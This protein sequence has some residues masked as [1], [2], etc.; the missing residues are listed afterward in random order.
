MGSY[1]SKEAP[2]TG[3]KRTAEERDVPQKREATGYQRRE[4]K[5]NKREPRGHSSG[6]FKTKKQMKKEKWMKDKE[7]RKKKR[8]KMDTMKEEEKA[9]VQP[10]AGESLVTGVQPVGEINDLTSLVTRKQTVTKEVSTT[11]GYTTTVI[12]NTSVS[13][14]EV[15]SVDTDMTTKTGD[16]VRISTSGRIPKKK[17][18][19]MLGYNGAGFQGLQINPKAHTIE[20][21]VF[22]ALCRAGAISLANQDDPKKSNWM[23]SARTDKGVSAAGN[24]ISLKMQLPDNIVDRL[25]K[26]LP[27]QIRVWGYVV[28]VKSFHAK[29][30]CDSRIYEYLLPTCAFMDPI[31]RELKDERTLETDLTISNNDYENPIIKYVA[32][33][34]P[35]EREMRHKYRAPEDRL[36]KFRMAIEQ[37]VGSHNFH[38][39]TINKG[40]NDKSCNRYIKSIT[41]SDP[42]YIHD[43]EW[44]SIK[45]H[46]QSFMLHQIRKM[47][48][49]G[50]LLAR[51]STPISLIPETF[52][53]RRINIPKAPALGLLLERPI[54]NTYNEKVLV[55]SKEVIR[56]KLTFDPYAA[57]IE[58]FKQEQIYAKIF[59]T[60][61]TE[62]VFDGYLT[63]LDAHWGTDFDYLNEEGVIPDRC[64]ITTKYNPQEEEDEEED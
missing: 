47:I 48:S 7:E 62:H 11:N 34:T 44:I 39:Y 22:D 18:A 10:T 25:N 55:K 40:A 64:L 58:K 32:A 51:T 63:S 9:P 57:E 50:L 24:V 3:V 26:I 13:S 41:V 12:T 27:P 23:R 20:G 61:N 42:M 31:K 17:V 52:K 16:T 59:E 38:N 28:V 54:F 36:L 60:E 37:Y 53:L 43:T 35:E 19:L 29:Y 33:S 6:Q 46:G 30:L 5:G 1:F 49:M 2:V 8:S 45:L 4:G 14:S 21:V 15:N 56:E